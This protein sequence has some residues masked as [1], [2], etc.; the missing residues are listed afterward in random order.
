MLVAW[1]GELM[2]VMMVVKLDAISAEKLVLKL[3]GK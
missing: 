2:A 3:D 1:K